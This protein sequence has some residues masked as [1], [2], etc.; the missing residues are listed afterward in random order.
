MCGGPAPLS[1]AAV[2]QP[3]RRPRG[4]S[5]SGQPPGGFRDLPD[6]A[7]PPE[8][9]PA[10][11]GLLASRWPALP[12]PWRAATGPGT[13]QRRAPRPAACGSRGPAP[14]PSQPPV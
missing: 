14:H 11:P 5:R 12:R 7:T 8:T 10:W 6:R 4:P 2:S 9:R 1:P 3:S 13:A